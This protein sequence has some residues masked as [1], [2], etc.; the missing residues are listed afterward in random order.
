MH[1]QIAVRFPV[2]LYLE[3]IYIPSFRLEEPE[4]ESRL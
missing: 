3:T 2:L 4:N 1:Q